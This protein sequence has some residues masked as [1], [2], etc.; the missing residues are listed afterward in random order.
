MSLFQRSLL[1]GRKSRIESCP[2]IF[3]AA[4]G[5]LQTMQGT[6]RTLLQDLV[7]AVIGHAPFQHLV[8][9]AGPQQGAMVFLSQ[10]KIV[11]Y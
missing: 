8:T 5:Q 9:I 6:G 7:G 10:T 2:Q 1:F 11:E 3:T 4:Q